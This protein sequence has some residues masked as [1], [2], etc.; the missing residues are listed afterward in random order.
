MRWP[1]LLFAGALLL[2]LVPS[3]QALPDLEPNSMSI[4]P[5]TPVK[6]EAFDGEVWVRNNGDNLS[7][8]VTVMILNSSA[9][10]SLGEDC[11]IVHQETI[12]IIGRAENVSVT[13]NW[14]GESTSGTHL[15]TTRIDQEDSIPES[16]EDNN[17]LEFEYE[18]LESYMPNLSFVAGPPMFLEPQVP[19]VGDP[20]DIVVLF[21]N[22]GHENTVATSFQI[23]FYSILQPD[24]TPE[25]LEQFEVRSLYGG[26]TAQMNITWHPDVAGDYLLRVVLDEG[27]EVDESLEDDNV[28]EMEVMVR[29]HTPELTLYEAPGLEILPR[30]DWLDDVFQHHQVE[31]AV[32]VLNMDPVESATEV[33][34]RFWDQPEGGSQVIIGDAMLPLVQNATRFEGEVVPAPSVQALVVW[35]DTAL[36]GTHTIFVEIDPLDAIEEWYEDDNNFNFSLTVREP[37]PDLNVTSLVVPGQAVYGIPSAVEVSVFNTGAAATGQTEVELWIDDT[38]VYTWGLSLEEGQQVLLI[39][40]YTWAEDWPRVKARADASRD[41]DELDENNNI[42]TVLVDVAAPHRDIAAE[43]LEVPELVFEGQRV[44]MMVTLQNIAAAAPEFRVHLY[45]GEDSSPEASFNGYDLGYNESRRFPVWLNNTGGMLGDYNLTVEVEVLGTYKDENH[46][47]DAVN[48]SIH[49]SLREYDLAVELGYLANTLPVNRTIEITVHAFNHGQ[50]NLE[51]DAMGAEVAVYINGVEL[52]LMPTGRLGMVTGEQLLVFYWTPLQVGSYVIEAVIDPYNVIVEPDESDNRVVQEVNV[53][54]EQIPVTPTPSGGESIISQP[55]VWV[56]L[57][58]L[59][60]VG[61]GMFA[62]YRLRGEEDYLPGYGA[63]MQQQPP[64]GGPARGTTTFRYDHDSGI[65]Y[66]AE[67]GEVI[68]EKKDAETGD[69]L[70]E[71][72]DTEIGKKIRKIKKK[73]D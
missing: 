28:A 24:G 73:K 33:R 2:L 71:T 34:V 68:G 63:E 6:G 17:D 31:L 54:V 5:Q 61:A 69:V 55:L 37:L 56:P 67:T 46:S 22:A 44:K 14:R 59:A 15:L 57:L 1:L 45:L 60:I 42:R 16:N 53:T 8:N 25:L 9:D 41:L 18:V 49:F 51:S 50:T 10:C 43:T 40:D 26:E 29:E 27:N 65:T 47:N 39:Y 52:D 35:N 36:A 48:G 38:R 64:G 30:D 70:G 3:A 20:A 66:D 12:E 32:Y 72:K 58:V 11:E 62:Y 23:A 7:I 21:E 13:F 4:S 19:A